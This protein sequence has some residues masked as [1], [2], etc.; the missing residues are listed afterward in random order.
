MTN[1]VAPS[2][3]ETPP[4]AASAIA[5]LAATGF[6][7]LAFVVAIGAGAVAGLETEVVMRRGVATLAICWPV[8]WIVLRVVFAAVGLGAVQHSDDAPR[9]EGEVDHIERA[10]IDELR[11]DVNLEPDRAA[12]R[13]SESSQTFARARPE[14]NPTVRHDLRLRAS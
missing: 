2:S 12:S 4:I 14:E 7:L 11:L 1:P 9:A 6:A 8:G 10:E 3:E 13:T 5:T